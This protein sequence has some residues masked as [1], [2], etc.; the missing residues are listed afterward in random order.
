[1]ARIVVFATAALGLLP[2]ALGNELVR[3]PFGAVGFPIGS[4]TC[5]HQALSYL[6]CKGPLSPSCAEQ[7]AVQA[8]SF[9]SSYLSKT[10]TAF[11]TVTV[12]STVVSTGTQTLTSGATATTTSTTSTAT[13]T[14]ETSTETDTSTSTFTAAT[15]YIP[16]PLP[17]ITEKKL[18]RAAAAPSVCPDLSKKGLTRLRPAKVSSICSCLGIKA[19]TTTTTATDTESTTTT[20]PTT[21]STTTTQTSTSTTVETDVST[22]TETTSTT[23]TTGVVATTTAIVDYCDLTYN[24]GGVPPGDTV[25]RPPGDLSGR[26]CCVLCWN[27][28]N[29]VAAANGLGYCQLLIRTSTLDGAP[30]SDQCPLGI[31]NYTYLDGPGTLYRG[32]CSP[33]LN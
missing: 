33:G 11:N 9:C 14:T 30:T 15:S 26:D 20:T 23:T 27:T 1:M 21:T 12:V 8:A 2:T 24:G 28:A 10:A 3:P 6:N 25:I 13:T 29:C 31:E 17:T 18:K 7:V 16:P 22:T 19:Q 5:G 32:P 4:E